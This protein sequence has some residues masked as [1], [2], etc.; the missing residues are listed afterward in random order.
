M[1]RLRSL[2]P[3]R[4]GNRRF[5][6]VA[7]LPVAGLAALTTL[8]SISLMPPSVH[9]KSLA[10][11]FASSQVYV[12]APANPK[13]APALSYLFGPWADVLAEEMTSP[14]VRGLIASKAGIP[15]NQLAIDGPVSP[16]LQR[17]Q[18]EP[19]GEKRSSQLVIEGARYR[20]ELNTDPDLAAIGISGEAPTPAGAIRLVRAAEVAVNS[21]LTHA[22]ERSGTPPKA[23]LVVN[24]LAP[25]VLSGGAGGHTLTVLVFVIVFVLW[26]GLIALVDKLRRELSTIAIAQ[27]RGIAEIRMPSARSS[28]SRHI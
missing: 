14:E 2:I 3:K 17:T 20:I 23:R 4:L 18:Q 7:G 24:P 11:S 6:I 15:V 19:T 27:K 16:N 26:A 13:V 5:W 8:V 25:V 22:E 10:H 12:S 21:Y 28:V 1:H 9:R